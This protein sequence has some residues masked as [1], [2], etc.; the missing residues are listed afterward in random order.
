MIGYFHM[1]KKICFGDPRHRLI[2]SKPAKLPMEQN[3][4]PNSNDGDPLVNPTSY[5]KLINRLLYLTHTRS[6]LLN[7]TP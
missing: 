2:S 4:K 1:S 5:Q 7:S 6:F 3:L